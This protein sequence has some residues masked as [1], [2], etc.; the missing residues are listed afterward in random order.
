MVSP[1]RQIVLLSDGT[2]NSRGK[3]FTTNVWRVYEALDLADPPKPEQ[4][5]Q[6]AFYD[7]G[8]GSSSFKPSALLGG[9]LG[10]GLAR[11]V[12]DLYRFLC[13]TYRP[14]DRI[15]AF[16]FSRGAFTIRVLVGLIVNQG[17]V[18]YHGDEAEL[19]RLA[20]A[21]Y[22]AYRR[23]YRLR[24][25]YIGPL[26]DLRDAAIAWRARRSGHTPYAAVKK[27]GA[28]DSERP[29]EIEFLGLW[30]TVDA[31]GLPVDELTRA[32]DKVVWPV[33][34]RDLT[35]HARVKR[36]V[37]ALALDDE[38]NTFHPRLWNAEAPSAP[39]LGSDATPQCPYERISQVWF[40]GMH[41]DVGGGYPD[42]GLSHVSLDW[43]ADA[44]A[45]CGLRFVKRLRDQQ[46]ALSDENGPMND[47][48]RGLAGYYRY[49]PRRLEQLMAAT[50]GARPKV[51][52]SA[53][54]RIRIG[55]D[56]YAPIVLPPEFDV[57]HLDGR[58]ED[59]ACYLGIDKQKQQ[60][61]KYAADRERVFNLVWRKR[62][63]YFGTLAF[64]F[65][66]LLLPLWSDVDR[67]ACTSRLCVLSPLIRALDVAL[68]DMLSGWTRWYSTHPGHFVAL[69]LPVAL[70]LWLG[71]RL[72]RSIGDAMRRVWYAIDKSRPSSVAQAP[73][74][75]PA[76]H[77]EQALQWL[78]TSRGYRAG[79]RLLTWRVL[80]AGFLAGLL[81]GV[82]VLGSVGLF[83]MAA[84]SGFVCQGSRSTE[85]VGTSPREFQLDTRQV[86]A[87]T[88]LKLEAG[89]TYRFVLTL[90][91]KVGGPPIVWRD[92][93]SEDS[94]EADLR[95]VRPAQLTW[96]MRLGTP[97]RREVAR[98][99]LAP[100]A[101]IGNRGVDLYPL[102][103]DPSVPL[104][105]PLTVL[106]TQLVAR[107]S[108]ELFLY[109]NDAV[110]PPGWSD[111][112]YLNNQGT[113][114]VSVSRVAPA[115]AP[116]AP[117]SLPTQASEPKPP[118]GR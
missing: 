16:G 80:P 107:S 92:G 50:G 41:S 10:V 35:L 58:I 44:A 67:Q 94:P 13:R 71:G 33:T 91:T 1:P 59:G 48:R 111:F 53:L 81:Y 86:C 51:H 69:A 63:V 65:V 11:N 102:T 29:V 31:Y 55:Q 14:G 56:A 85:R 103:P 38:R 114:Q 12:R 93:R 15:Y 30:D 43:V 62:L 64:T 110:G 39:P 45:A 95:G 17:I 117:P 5:R 23:R 83:A 52:E 96:A 61:Q 97:L 77:I 100:M 4:P 25:N 49:N 73:V 22:R 21:A 109:V 66:L 26:R 72:Q 54:R 27:I 46:H 60:Q 32:V 40:A 108:G 9:A 47:S 88:G 20:S 99:Y 2:G 3:H 89:G 112:F 106:D 70:G 118:H 101:R 42:Q 84:S 75:K 78:R 19:D 90:P 6:F 37:H 113:A 57:L 8:V 76:G 36:A 82:V 115:A 74:S 104:D 18:P 79:F 34:M 87:G 116:L 28:P 24:F 105:R 68:P 98:P 7:D